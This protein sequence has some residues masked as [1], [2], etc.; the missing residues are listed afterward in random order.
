LAFR[1]SPQGS[2][3]WFGV[4]APVGALIGGLRAARDR[5]CY[6]EFVLKNPPNTDFFHDALDSPLFVT[7]HFNRLVPFLWSRYGR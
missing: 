7:P 5:C 1:P 2:S 4:L 3:C 6:D